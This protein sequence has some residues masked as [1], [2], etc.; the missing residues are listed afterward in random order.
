[1]RFSINRLWSVRWSVLFFASLIWLTIEGAMHPST[2]LSIILGV[3]ACLWFL[4][5]IFTD[6]LVDVY[7]GWWLEE[8]E[9]DN[10][11]QEGLGEWKW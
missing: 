4:L 8:I 1:M 10:K 2:T 7:R 3:F 6:K 11:Y 9:Q 5:Y